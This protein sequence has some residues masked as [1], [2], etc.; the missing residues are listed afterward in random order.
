MS[1][2]KLK[3]IFII[4]ALIFM[5]I[6]FFRP[7]IINARQGCCSHHDGVCGCGCCDGTSLSATCAPYYPNCNSNP[8]PQQSPAPL[9]P[10]PKIETKI[11]KTTE[12]IKFDTKQQDDSDLAKGEQ[13]IIIMIEGT[14]PFL[15]IKLAK[16]LYRELIL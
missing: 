10:Q 14:G 15:N 7:S 2:T 4:I 16:F 1:N 11:E 13:K 3:K 8:P 12:V 5:A 6:C 9:N